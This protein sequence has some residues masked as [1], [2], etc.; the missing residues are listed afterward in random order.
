MRLRS[1]V[2]HMSGSEMLT[3][4]F[5][6]AM[7]EGPFGMGWHDVGIVHPTRCS[8]SAVRDPPTATA[9]GR[10]SL[11]LPQGIGYFLSKEVSQKSARDLVT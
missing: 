1:S 3:Q 6:F 10:P 5:R 2:D 7:G 9:R 8:V 11:G 4:G